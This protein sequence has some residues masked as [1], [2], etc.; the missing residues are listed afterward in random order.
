MPTTEELY[1]SLH[2][3]LL[4]F[5]QSKLSDKRNAEDLVHDIFMR[6][7]EHLG[8][9]KDTDKVESWIYQIARNAIADDY[10]KSKPLSPLESHGES[11]AVPPPDDVSA[12]E[13]LALSTQ[14]F[15]QKL[16]EPYRTALTLTEFEGVSQSELAEKLGLSL[17]GAKSRVQR[18]RA[19]LKDLYL[20]CCTFE[21][22]RHK[23]VLNYKPKSDTNRCDC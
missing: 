12:I 21:Q 4:R 15:V 16:P 7:H 13:Y 20:E 17:S 2:T 6:V 1:Q 22:N 3:P 8:D 9:L 5:V 18:A 23:V 10:R 11:V 19:M 14:D